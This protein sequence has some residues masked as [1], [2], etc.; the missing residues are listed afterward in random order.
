MRTVSGLF[1]NHDDARNAVA[2]LEAVGV[3][4]SDISLIANNADNRYSDSDTNAAEGAGAGASLGAAGGGAV[5]LLT[6]LGLMAIPGV[7]PV[8]A[9]GWLASTAAGAAAGAVAG[10]AVGGMIGAMTNSGV[11]ESDAHVYAEGVRRGGSVVTA[12]VDEGL[13]ADA[14]A[15]LRANSVDPVGRRQAYAEAGWQRFDDRAAPY[16]AS[17]IEEERR[18]YTRIP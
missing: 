15:I 16:S 8:V 11:N 5:G 4:S 7:G 12:R 10:G 1:D 13:V 6:G 2:Q 17:E 9:A 14:E 3:P 18:R